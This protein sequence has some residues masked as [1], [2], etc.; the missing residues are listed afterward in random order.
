MKDHKNISYR[1]E[2]FEQY[3]SPEQ[4]ELPSLAQ[5]EAELDRENYKRNYN[6]TLR[7]TLAIL[8]V[9]AAVVIILAF[10]IFPVFRIYGSSMSPTLQEGEIVLAMRTS[11]FH[12]GDIVMLS[13]NNKLL[14]KRVIAGPG[15]WVNIDVDGTVYVDSRP[16]S[17]PYLSAKSYGDCN[18]T[19]PYQVPDGKYFVMGDNR[20]TSLDSRNS[21]VGCFSEEQITGKAILRIW[22]LESFGRIRN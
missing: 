21:S 19:F 9:T 14:V 5:L 3:D 15:Q 12:T 4:Q 10:L 13:Y 11:A 20:A 8:L 7:N 1:S 6:S 2:A 18:L 16:L 22:P 17:E